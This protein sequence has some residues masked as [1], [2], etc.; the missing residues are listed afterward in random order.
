MEKALSAS[1]ACVLGTE[2]ALVLLVDE[3]RQS[4]EPEAR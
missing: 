2:K 4:V 1:L 3:S